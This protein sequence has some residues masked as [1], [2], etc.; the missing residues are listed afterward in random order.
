MNKKKVVAYIDG[1]NVYH[2]IANNLPQKYKWLDY[3][4]F[5]EEFLEPWDE[6]KNIFLFTASPKWDVERMQRHRDFME[7]MRS[8]GIIIISGNYATVV[9]KFNS[10]KNVVISPEWARVDPSKF[11]YSTFEEKQ[12]DVNIAL[13]IFEGAV[14]NSYDTALIFSGDSDI[15]PGIRKAKKYNP[16]VECVAII[17]YNGRWRVI[18]TSCNSPKTRTT[19][20]DQISSCL[21]PDEIDIWYKVIKNPYK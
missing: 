3:R 14:M 17:P 13:S 21:L 9:R 2:S 5:V 1:F 16:R 19:T 8:L 18:A 10:A 12:T 20:L 15:A 6:L 7:V 4:A 11:S